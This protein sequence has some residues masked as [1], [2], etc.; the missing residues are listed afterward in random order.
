MFTPGY[1]SLSKPASGE[2]IE[3][4]F[5]ERI[6]EIRAIRSKEDPCNTKQAGRLILAMIINKGIRDP[7]AFSGGT[8]HTIEQNLEIFLRLAGANAAGAIRGGSRHAH[9]RDGRDGLGG[10]IAPRSDARRSL[11]GAAAFDH[12]P[13]RFGDGHLGAYHTEIIHGAERDL[14]PWRAGIVEKVQLPQAGRIDYTTVSE[15]IEQV[16]SMR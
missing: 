16:T 10:R 1:H 5:P 14:I 7:D 2:L 13:V 3:G 9:V 12:G 15:R 8:L 4:C 6:R 11:A